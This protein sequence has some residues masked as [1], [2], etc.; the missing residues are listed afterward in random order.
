[1]TQLFAAAMQRAASLTRAGNLAEAT[2]AIQAALG[3]H[4]T[5]AGE[6]SADA[7]AH[8]SV[9]APDVLDLTATEVN[10]P[11]AARSVTTNPA[12]SSSPAANP[13]A[14]K[15]AAFGRARPALRRSLAETVRGLAGAKRLFEGLADGVRGPAATPDVP[16]GAQYLS[17]E[18][19]CPAGARPYRVY[20][21]ASAGDRPAGLVLMLHGCKQN[22]DDFAVGTGMNAKAE[23]ERMIVVYPGQLSAANPSSCWNW[24]SP[25][26]QVRGAGEP[27]ILA[28]L[29]R[30]VADEFAVPA[31]SVYVAGLSAGGAMAAILA[32]AYPDVFAA[33]GIHSGLPAGSASDVASAFAAMGGTGQP[34]PASKGSTTARLI[35]FHGTADRTVHPSN[36]EAI[37]AARATGA[38]S[39]DRAKGTSAAGRSFTRVVHRAADGIAA[40]EHWILDGLGH[41]WSGGA[42]AGSYTDPAGPD[43]S[44]E[45]MRFFREPAAANR[46]G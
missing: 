33:A 26:D 11:A 45:M 23:A 16:P 18:F 2:R 12:A 28:A 9:A 14:A 34:R 29:A 19:T 10:R 24:F 8:P 43:A 38:A 13:A 5:P 7:A 20:I 46:A 36:G 3:G 25:R 39:V 4:G 30:S 15:P 22:P 41:A 31:D 44:A 40:A 1:M 6:P 17:R 35:V 37:V 27:A 42:A 32:E 21:P